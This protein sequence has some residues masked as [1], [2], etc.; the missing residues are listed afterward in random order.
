MFS[1]LNFGNPG[2]IPREQR[3]APANI[4]AN[5]AAVAR[6]LGVATR[7]IVQVHQVHGPAVHV[8]ELEAMQSPEQ[9]RADPKADAIVTNAPVLAGIRTA[10]CAPILLASR[11][12][13]IVGAVH[14]GWRG[15]V[16]GVLPETIKIMR[17]RGA[18]NIVASIG[19]CI[20]QQSFEVDTDVADQ[21]D[22]CFGKDSKIAAELPRRAGVEVKKYGIDLQRALRLQ[23]EQA[24]IAAID[25]IPHCTFERSDLYF[26]HRREK[27]L[28]GRMIALIGPVS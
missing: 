14:A 19:P 6:A 8:V 24:D 10:D 7:P 5:L 3:D 28:T 17:A 1:S 22:K 21:F 15:V 12:G 25:V 23:L 2:D 20:G 13:A 4:A 18:K 16:G 27:G 26:S 9:L 11:D